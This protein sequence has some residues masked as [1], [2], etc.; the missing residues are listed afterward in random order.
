VLWFETCFEFVTAPKQNYIVICLNE[1]GEQVLVACHRGILYVISVRE[2]R[3]TTRSPRDLFPERESFTHMQFLSCSILVILASNFKC[4]SASRYVCHFLYAYIYFPVILHG[5]CWL[6]LCNDSH[7]ASIIF[8]KNEN[9]DSDYCQFLC[10][11][12]W[13][14]SRF[15]RQMDLK[16]SNAAAIPSFRPKIFCI[17]SKFLTRGNI[18]TCTNDWEVQI[19]YMAFHVSRGCARFESRLGHLKSSDLF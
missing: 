15:C 14:V 18:N 9:R 4:F 5:L 17:R 12:V 13:N 16:A 19:R 8:R 1:N 3:K 11:C 6:T 10:V 2:H 7:G